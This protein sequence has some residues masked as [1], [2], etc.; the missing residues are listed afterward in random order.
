MNDR[1][2]HHHRGF[3][4]VGA[5]MAALFL[6]SSASPA[7]D[8]S[9]TIDAADRPLLASCEDVRI[10]FGALG[11]SWETVRSD[12]RLAVPRAEAAPLRAMVSHAGGIRVQ[13]W[14]QSDYEV[15]VCKAA[16]GK[17]REEA[18][19][20]LDEVRVERRGGRI[21]DEGP[22]PQNRW[23]V[24]LI[25]RVPK[26]ASVDVETVNG[27]IEV[28]EVEGTI[29]ARSKNGPIA[30]EE[31]AGDVEARTLNGPVAASGGRGKHHLSTQNGPVAVALRGTAWDGAGLSAETSN[32]PVALSLAP[33]YATG[34][35]VEASGNSPWV[36]QG[37]ACSAARRARGEGRRSLTFGDTEPIIRLKTVNGPVAIDSPGEDDEYEISV[38]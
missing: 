21:T 19:K 1:H 25:L 36:C 8:P 9:L 13:S 20:L 27:E 31:C 11:G 17:D 18:Q 35:R 24:Y 38:Q 34:V 32:G 14:D 22:D 2:H 26:G 16:A 4:R 10:R 5:A 7:H 29:V 15:E 33:D 12:T 3:G 6:A 37:L 28:N 23:V 30:I